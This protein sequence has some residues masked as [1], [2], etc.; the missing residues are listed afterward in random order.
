MPLKFLN[1]EYFAE[2]QAPTQGCLFV[3]M[4]SNI[5][6]RRVCDGIVQFDFPISG[7]TDVGGDSYNLLSV[8]PQSHLMVT[9]GEIEVKYLP[10]TNK[11]V[12]RKE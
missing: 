5:I 7:E 2:A 3:G 9:S 8:G 6:F 10:I 4:S 11:K 12:G 1:F